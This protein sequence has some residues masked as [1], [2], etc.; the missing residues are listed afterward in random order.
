MENVQPLADFE[1]AAT[2]QASSNFQS[3]P[4][5]RKDVPQTVCKYRVYSN[6]QEF[7]V[8]DAATAIGALDASGYANAYKIVREDPMAYTL[9]ERKTWHEL[10]NSAAARQA[11]I[12]QARTEAKEPAAPIGAEAQASSSDE[13]PAS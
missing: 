6:A 4:L 3:L 12:A 13:Q 2:Q 7:I 8:V 10:E 11:T 1:P 9:I 5:P